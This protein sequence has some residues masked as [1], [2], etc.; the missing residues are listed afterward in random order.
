MITTMTMMNE[1]DDDN[2]EDDNGAIINSIL[3]VSLKEVGVS[4]CLVTFWYGQ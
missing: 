4:T 1:D 2:Y 3:M